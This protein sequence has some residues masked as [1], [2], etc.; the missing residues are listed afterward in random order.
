MDTHWQSIQVQTSGDTDILDVT[1]QVQE[2]VRS[3]GI[4]TGQATA[5][6]IGSTAALTTLE[7]EPGL[8]NHDI[9][10]A[11]EKIAPQDG[12]YLHEETWHDD[13]G[14]SHVRAALIGPSLALPVVEGRVPLGTWQQIVLIDFDT[15]PRER[16][17]V[18]TV[19]G[20]RLY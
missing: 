12:R 9:A 17:V 4:R 2:V 18:V 7:Y 19:I 20:P 10:A 5:M 13:N 1:A 8:V 11:L 6:V 16:E 14:H 15:R 3:S